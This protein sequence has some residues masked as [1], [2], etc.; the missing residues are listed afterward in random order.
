MIFAVMLIL[1]GGTL[2]VVVKLN[3]K[4]D[5]K[6]NQIEIDEELKKEIEE[7]EN[8]YNLNFED[9]KIT[10]FDDS[11]SSNEEIINL[12]SFKSSIQ[13]KEEEQQKEEIKK[14]DSKINEPIKTKNDNKFKSFLDMTDDEFKE[15]ITDENKIVSEMVMNSSKDVDMQILQNKLQT[16]KRMKNIRD[17]QIDKEFEII[18]I[19]GEHKTET[20]R[21]NYI[22][23]LRI[24]NFLSKNGLILTMDKIRDE[25]EISKLSIQRVSILLKNLI[26]TCNIQKV[27]NNDETFFMYATPIGYDFSMLKNPVWEANFDVKNK[28]NKTNTIEPLELGDLKEKDFEDGGVIKTNLTYL[29][30]KYLNLKTKT[31]PNMNSMLNEFFKDIVSLIRYEDYKRVL[32]SSDVNINMI[33]GVYL[34]TLRDFLRKIGKDDKVHVEKY[35][36]KLSDMHKNIFMPDEEINKISIIESL[37]N[38][39]DLV[40]EN[41]QI[42][43]INYYNE[44]S[45]YIKKAIAI[46]YAVETI[47]EGTDDKN[48]FINKKINAIKLLKYFSDGT[49]FFNDE[50]IEYDMTKREVK[51]LEFNA[52]HIWLN[53]EILLNVNLFIKE[54][55]NLVDFI[56]ENENLKMSL[57]DLD[58]EVANLF[59]FENV[60]SFSYLNLFISKYLS[61]KFTDNIDEI[62]VIINNKETE[63][64]FKD[65]KEK[66]TMLINLLLSYNGISSENKKIIFE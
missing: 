10:E 11:F 51:G 17:N 6:K 55:M 54:T 46:K 27:E 3:D 65:I 15:M 28:D 30:E 48:L 35:S 40:S 66:V 56:E 59:N 63:E 19:K 37:G 22:Y 24:L 39:K 57:D 44:D 20:A 31:N 43:N 41:L 21:E 9:D 52:E 45:K 13:I 7:L 60:T 8:E 42:E 26:D 4:K 53:P 25:E 29:L 50:Q 61:L 1:A 36:N 2:F 49:V 32:S 12:D 38:L 34:Y 18:R 64:I 16:L 5:D 23:K 47:T 62:K 58:R 33:K 14:A